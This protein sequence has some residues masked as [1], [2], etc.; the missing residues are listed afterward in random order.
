MENKRSLI[1]VHNSTKEA[2]IKQKLVECETFDSIVCRAL[3][4]LEYSK[5]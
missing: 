5:H 4:A 3:K 2:L 1:V